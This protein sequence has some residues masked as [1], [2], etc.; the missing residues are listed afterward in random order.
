MNKLKKFPLVSRNS[1]VF[2]HQEIIWIIKLKN[3]VDKNLLENDYKFMIILYL[4]KGQI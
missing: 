2:I 1:D 3:F 4:I